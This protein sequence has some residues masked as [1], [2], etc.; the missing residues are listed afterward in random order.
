[1]GLV[2]THSCEDP[3]PGDQLTVESRRN[4]PPISNESLEA[5][6]SIA[7]NNRSVCYHK[8][9]Y[10]RNCDLQPERTPNF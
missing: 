5:V 4:S 6:G 10:W 2:G 9:P 1:M 7:E 8:E 3:G